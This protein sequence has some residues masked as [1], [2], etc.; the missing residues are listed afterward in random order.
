M[1][2]FWCETNSLQVNCNKTKLMEFKKSHDRTPSKLTSLTING[3]VIEKV[4]CFKYLGVYFDSCMSFWP[5]IKHLDN[6]VIS[7]IAQISFMKRLVPPNIFIQLVKS[8]VIS[9]LDYWIT[10]WGCATE[11]E[12]NRIQ[13]KIDRLILCYFFPAPSSRHGERT[14]VF[15]LLTDNSVLLTP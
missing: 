9:H 3:H 2:E 6:K 15:L 14:C 11:A 5:H 4:V 1:R 10:V 7:S 13:K 8:L 12:L